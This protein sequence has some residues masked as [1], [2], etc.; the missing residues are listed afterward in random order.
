MQAYSYLPLLEEMGYVP[1]MKFAYGFEI[2]EYCQNMAEKFGFYDHCLFHA[3]VQ[4]TEW[5]EQSG[6]WTVYTDRGDA[7]RA[8]FA[9]LANGILTTPKLAHIEGMESFVGDAFRT[10]CW[11]YD[12]DLEGKKVGIIGTGAAAVQVI[13]EIA[14][15]VK[16]LYVFQRTPSSIDVRDQ[17]ETTQEEIDAWAHEPGWAKAR[18]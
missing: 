9:V 3:T 7:M 18:R 6:R 13:A 16:E 15:V 11:N 10:L 12:V 17:G 5:D 8:G 2:M 14:K 4:R 1:T